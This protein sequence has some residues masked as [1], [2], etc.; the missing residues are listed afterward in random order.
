MKIQLF[1][2]SLDI[3]KCI[4]WQYNDATNL[5]SLLEQKQ[6]W[7]DEEYRDFWENWF[8]N[9]FQLDTLN[10]FG[11][12]LWSIILGVNF[13]VEIPPVN[14]T[15]AFGFNPYGLNFYNGNFWQSSE[16][17]GLSLTQK[18]LVLKLRYYQLIARGTIPETNRFMKQVFGDEGTVYVQDLYDMTFAVYV[19]DFVPDSQ[20]LFVLQQFDLLPRPAGVGIL[21]TILNRIPFGF[22]PFDT[23]FY[24]GN[25]IGQT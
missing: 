3:L 20:T 8:V 4:L 15:P 13:F 22:D 1:D 23:N 6:T 24:D 9:C 7:Y 18:R 19:F 25:F 5:Q 2:D 10:E 21:L 12:D 11:C 17:Q 16:V 14:N